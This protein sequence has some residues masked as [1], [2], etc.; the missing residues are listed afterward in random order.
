LEQENMNKQKITF[1]IICVFVVVFQLV[2]HIQTGVIAG[3]SMM[4]YVLIALALIGKFSRKKITILPPFEIFVAH[5]KSLQTPIIHWISISK[6]DAGKIR[7]IISDSY[8][9]SFGE[10]DE[11][12]EA[13]FRVVMMKKEIC[14]SMKLEE[15]DF[16]RIS[17]SHWRKEISPIEG[18]MIYSIYTKY[19]N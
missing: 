10:N 18:D 16:V 14:F 8:K 12:D 15:R 1:F 13:T 17:N 3:S 7:G 5:K 11:L 6:V 4:I 19:I 2:N 9:L